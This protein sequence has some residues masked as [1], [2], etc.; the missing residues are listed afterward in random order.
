LRLARAEL[1]RPADA[2]GMMVPVVVLHA[3]HLD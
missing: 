2:G 1:D 3:K